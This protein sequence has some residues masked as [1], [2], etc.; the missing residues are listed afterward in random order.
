M[1]APR[2]RSPRCNRSSTEMLV[3]AAGKCL[4]GAPR[5]LLACLTI[6]P[7]DARVLREA[8]ER[9]PGT[10]PCSMRAAPA[11]VEAQTWA[12]PF[13]NDPYQAAAALLSSKKMARADHQTLLVGNR[14]GT[15]FYLSWETGT[16]TTHGRASRSGR[17]IWTRRPGQRA[18]L[19]KYSNLSRERPGTIEPAT[20]WNRVQPRNGG[21]YRCYR[22]AAPPA[23]AAGTMLR[24]CPTSLASM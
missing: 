2:P 4:G 8:A 17:T 24:S 22:G 3:R 13:L 20:R 10:E 16:R 5:A 9:C 7:C 14:S 12:A 21:R 1:L 15:A 19:K 6:P 18:Q 11:G 23:G